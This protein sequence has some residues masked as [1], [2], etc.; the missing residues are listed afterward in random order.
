M[1]IIPIE[2]V[3][4]FKSQGITEPEDVEGCLSA[5]GIEISVMY[6][7]DT[8]HEGYYDSINEAIEALL[9]LAKIHPQLLNKN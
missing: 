6:E 1:F 5:T 4:Y 8:C 9:K 7:D 3:E 2:Y